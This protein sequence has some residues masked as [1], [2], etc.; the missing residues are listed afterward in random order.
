MK[1]VSYTFTK[2]EIISQI[3]KA[4]EEVFKGM[5]INIAMGWDDG[6]EMAFLKTFGNLENESN[7]MIAQFW[8]DFCSEKFYTE[9]P[10]VSDVLMILSTDVLKT[11]VFIDKYWVC[12][13]TPP[14][15]SGN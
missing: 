3:R 11:E 10:D 12:N 9:N 6:S 13:Y 8:C 15:T 2:S 4:N 1:L 7:D 5:G 14:K